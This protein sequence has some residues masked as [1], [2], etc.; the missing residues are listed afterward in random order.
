M[1]S[2]AEIAAKWKDLQWECGRTSY[3]APY[4]N[5]TIASEILRKN[6]V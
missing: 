6:R 1:P 3:T 4:Q 2:L 5:V